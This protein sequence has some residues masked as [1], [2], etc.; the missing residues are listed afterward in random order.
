MMCQGFG[1]YERVCDRDPDPAVSPYFCARC[2]ALRGSA[3]EEAL[4]GVL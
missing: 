3:I 4:E 1:P 2:E